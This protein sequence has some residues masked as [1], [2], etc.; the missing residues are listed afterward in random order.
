MVTRVTPLKF[1]NSEAV[2]SNFS[3]QRENLLRRIVLLLFVCGVLLLGSAWQGRAQIPDA[4]SG[5]CTN[6]VLIW[7]EHFEE[8]GYPGVECDVSKYCC[9]NG[10]SS[11]PFESITVYDCY[12]ESEWTEWESGSANRSLC[13]W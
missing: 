13:G 8:S 7:T 9:D 3:K 12:G 5:F 10:S 11:G 6:W 2:G 4:P 1:P